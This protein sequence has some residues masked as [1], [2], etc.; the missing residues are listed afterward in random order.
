MPG[1]NFASVWMSAGTL[2]DV[3]LLGDDRRMVARKVSSTPEDYS[4]GIAEGLAAVLADSGATPGNLASVVHATTVATNAILEQK[5]ARTGL[6][7][8]QGFREGVEAAAI[9]LLHAYANPAHER[10][11][12][13]R[14]RDAFPNGLNVTCSSGIL[15][16]IRAR[17]GD[18]SRM[19]SAGGG[20]Y[21]DP[22]ERDPDAVLEKRKP[23]I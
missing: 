21:G 3:V 23:H 1:L 22:R 18:I 20:G 8:T 17:E 14:L 6:I 9:S 11:V 13:E 19:V 15:R 16:E 5:G 12:A 7:T 4:R 10:Q 2:T